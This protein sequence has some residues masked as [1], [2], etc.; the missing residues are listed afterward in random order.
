MTAAKL[1]SLP[2]AS[3][4]RFLDALTD[5]EAAALLYNWDFW[6]RDNQLPP[7]GEWRVWVILAGRG[8]GK[9][10]S[11]AEWIRAQVERHGKGNIALVGPT[12]GDV[13]DIMLEG[14]SG[15]LQ[16]C[17]PW[18]RPR[19]QPSLR[20]VTWPN[21][22][23][24]HLYSA[25][26]PDR[27]RG[28]NHDAA[29][30]DELAAWMYL[31]ETWDNLEFGLRSGEDPRVVV[32]TTPKPRAKLREIL[33][34]PETRKTTGSTYENQANLAASFIRRLQRKY[35]GTRT[36]RQELY[37]ELLEQAEGALWLRSWF[38]EEGFLVPEPPKL[39]RVVIAIDP[40]AGEEN[41]ESSAET[42]IVAAGLGIDRHGYALADLSGRYAPAEWARIA[43][44]ARKT[45]QADR[46]VAEINNGGAMVGAT[47]RTVEP[48]VP[49]KALHAS[50]S[51][52]ARAEPVA[53]LYE[54]K[55]IH[56]THRFPRLED[57]LC[58]W[59]PLS[60]QPSPDRLDALVWAFTELMLTGQHVTPTLPIVMKGGP[61]DA[62]GNPV[63]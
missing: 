32:T 26:E 30:A 3:R 14:E 37:A 60:G 62:L 49:F 18:N 4:Q 9:T 46:I 17:P 47:I 39:L 8:W 31:E 24:A 40:Q 41:S 29:W 34:D 61:R 43:C 7:P 52:Q 58:N 57:Q 51:K 56:H 6:A 5:A 36:G 25:E 15:L 13:R 12:A 48:N 10:K 45:H 16:I 27:L 2:E 22:A 23:E 63:Q 44:E 53:A 28:P 38:E 55:R 1:A 42:G 33:A 20:K 50:R 21:G 19:Y 59:E 35:E 54:Q 11:G